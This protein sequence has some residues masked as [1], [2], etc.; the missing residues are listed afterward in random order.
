MRTLSSQEERIE[1]LTQHFKEPSF[2]AFIHWKGQ[3]CSISNFY[4]FKSVVLP[5]L[6]PD[7][8]FT[9]LVEDLKDLK[10]RFRL[11]K[12]LFQII[13]P[14][15]YEIVREQT[16]NFEIFSDNLGQIE[17]KQLDLTQALIRTHNKIHKAFLI[18]ERIKEELRNSRERQMSMLREIGQK[19]ENQSFMKKFLN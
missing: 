17:S 14:K 12:N 10:L 19:F 15:I 9:D 13:F 6:S 3:L 2:K 11:K 7:Y 8:E 1:E 5:S 16:K 18:N 4:L